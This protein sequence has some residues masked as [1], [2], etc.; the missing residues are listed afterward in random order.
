V[1]L[2]ALYLL[3]LDFHQVPWNRVPPCAAN[4]ALSAQARLSRVPE[5]HD[6]FHSN[7]PV[8]LYSEQQKV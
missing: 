7:L 2:I 1:Q 8:A 5:V 3:K 6:C 4:S